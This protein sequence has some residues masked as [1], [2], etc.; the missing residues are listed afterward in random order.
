MTAPIKYL[1][2]RRGTR[3]AEPFALKMV[4][5]HIELAVAAH[6]A[7]R[8]RPPVD[9][10]AGVEALARKLSPLPPLHKPIPFPKGA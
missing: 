3:P 7:K 4:E 1:A 10:F 8:A 2:G 9:H 5:R 6:F